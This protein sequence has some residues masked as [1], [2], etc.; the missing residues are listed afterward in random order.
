V[1]LHR[2]AATITSPP[3]DGGYGGVSARDLD[4]NASENVDLWTF[5]AGVWMRP[6]HHTCAPV[7]R[8]LTTHA[9]ESLDDCAALQTTN[10]RTVQL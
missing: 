6:P 3:C 5:G 2:V 7:A 10:S 8:C 4:S 1:A 9:L